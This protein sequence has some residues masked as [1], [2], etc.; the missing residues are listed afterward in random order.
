MSFSATAILLGLIQG[1][2]EFLPISSTGHLIVVEKL[3]S[4]DNFPIQL[5]ACVT[6]LGSVIALLYVYGGSLVKPM[7]TMTSDKNSRIFL[8]CVGIATVPS[9][10]IGALLYSS[11]KTVLYT[12]LTIA[13]ALLAGGLTFLYLGKKAPTVSTPTPQ[14]IK[15]WQAS[16]IGIT[17]ALA[18][19]P[20]VSRSGST[21]ASGVAVGMSL[22]AATEFSFLVAIPTLCGATLFDLYKLLPNFSIEYLPMLALGFCT[23][24]LASFVVI[25]PFVRLIQQRGLAPFGW[26]RIFLG[27]LIMITL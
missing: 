25:R 9:A 4:F 2:T 18:L 3:L 1:L 7:R 26:Y 6:Q 5:F 12:P 16:I 23:S 24:C 20:G 10:I 13:A 22:G 21:I 14:E 19:I 8:Y 11:I 17:Q 27:I 15:L